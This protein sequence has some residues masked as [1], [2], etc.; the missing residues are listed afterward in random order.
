MSTSWKLIR[1][2]KYSISNGDFCNSSSSASISS[3][4]S[5]NLNPQ[6]EGELYFSKPAVCKNHDV[7]NHRAVTRPET[8]TGNACRPFAA[9]IPRTVADTTTL[10]TIEKFKVP[11]LHATAEDHRGG[12]MART[13]RTNPA[14][15]C[16]S[17]LFQH[18]HSIKLNTLGRE[19]RK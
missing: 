9:A 3:Y 2:I 6:Y 19:R 15:L 17:V 18:V 8:D 13:H 4:Y 5:N 14:I 11:A 7:R 1:F 16:Y 10:T 12:E